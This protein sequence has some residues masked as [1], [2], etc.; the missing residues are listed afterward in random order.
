MD[1][2]DTILG[3]IGIAATNIYFSSSI[4]TLV[5]PEG[6]NSSSL[7]SAANTLSF[8]ST[9]IT[10]DYLTAMGQ[11]VSLTTNSQF[12]SFVQFNISATLTFSMSASQLEVMQLVVQSGATTLSSS[13][14]I[15]VNGQS[16][17]IAQ[18]TILVSANS[19]IVSTLNQCDSLCSCSGEGTENCTEGPPL[20][21]PLAWSGTNFSL[22]SS[23]QSL[24]QV[25]DA[26]NI[27]IIATTLEITNSSIQASAVGIYT[28]TTIISAQGNISAQGLGCRSKTGL[29]CGY[30]DVTLNQLL[31][32][33]G[34]GG[35][36]GGLGG[37][38]APDTCT[39]LAPRRTYGSVVF[40]TNK[41]SGGGN[42]L[43]NNLS[44]GGG[45]IVIQTYML[46]IDSTSEINADG[47]GGLY[48]GGGGSGGSINVQ[49]AYVSGKGEI[50]AMGGVGKSSG[51]GG[52][53]SLQLMMWLNGSIVQP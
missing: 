10:S 8:N 3:S 43:T 25:I 30:Y 5:V 20:S 18:G 17:L 14:L 35:S 11:T 12:E 29:G 13:A 22:P 24:I 44:S 41:G 36:Y 7:F 21:F 39:L 26:F 2:N 19:G 9:N 1:L 50:S 33:S 46:S 32:C 52:R 49:T 4:L 27:S 28:N 37:S 48:G 15:F 42:P 6:D 16:M 51:G 53:I 34:T 47:L 31:A 23:V 40:P 45:L 38:S